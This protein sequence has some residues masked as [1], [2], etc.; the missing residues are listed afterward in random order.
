MKK[1]KHFLFSYGTLQLEQVQVNNYGRLLTGKKDHLSS[2]KLEKLKITDKEVIAKSGKEFHPIA[3]KTNNQN[4][5]IEGTIFEITESE[6]KETDKYEVGDYK[7]IL[8]T[9]SSGQQA[10]V[11]IAVE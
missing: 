5:Y 11:Y 9:F 10:W 3:I 2:Y 1:N 7:R 8:E 6:L 4:D